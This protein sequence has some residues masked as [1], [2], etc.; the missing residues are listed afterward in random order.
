MNLI[1]QSLRKHGLPSSNTKKWKE[2]SSFHPNHIKW[3][4]SCRFRLTWKLHTVNHNANHCFCVLC[5]TSFNFLAGLIEAIETVQWEAG[6]RKKITLISVNSLNT[7]Y[8]TQFQ[9]ISLAKKQKNKKIEGRGEKETRDQL[10]IPICYWGTRRR[11][12]ETQE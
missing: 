4:V 1:T 2:A 11:C 9:N 6:G 7:N 5:I 10:G 3:L 8:N 12:A